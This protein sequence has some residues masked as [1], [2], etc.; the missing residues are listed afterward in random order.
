MSVYC[1]NLR[2]CWKILVIFIVRPENSLFFEEF[3]V[4]LS[5]LVEHIEVSLVQ[6]VSYLMI[7]FAFAIFLLTLFWVT[8]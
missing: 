7:L 4:N 5:L 2:N 1:S 3:R 8:F 6:E